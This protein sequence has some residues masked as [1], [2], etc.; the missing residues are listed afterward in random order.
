MSAAEKQ[1][2]PR[3][4][5]RKSEA[6]EQERDPSDHYPTPPELCAAVCA[7]LWVSI[8]DVAHVIEPSAGGGNFVRAARRRW[9]AA[10]VTAIEPRPEAESGLRPITQR[11]IVDTWEATSVEIPDGPLLIIGN[12]PFSFALRHIALALERMGQRE[13]IRPE[14]R[15]LAFV[16]PSAFLHGID[17]YEALY[18]REP[19]GDGLFGQ[20]MALG[21]LRFYWPI[22][23][24]GSFDGTG[25]ADGRE[26]SV[27]V[28]QVGYFGRPEVDWLTWR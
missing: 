1:H 16:L 15:W 14:P 18:S 13:A 27:Y 5:P 20:M 22:V 9:P 6:G 21:G 24:R 25:K 8:G 7:R 11:V 3:L 17:R 19:I 2:I 12:P 28:W 10:H 23:Q 4:R 26:H